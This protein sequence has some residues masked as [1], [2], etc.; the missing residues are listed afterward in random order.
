M[1]GWAFNRPAVHNA[2]ASRNLRMLEYRN[3]NVGL[4]FEENPK[5]NPL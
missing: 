4:T 2:M 3:L 5:F 1:L